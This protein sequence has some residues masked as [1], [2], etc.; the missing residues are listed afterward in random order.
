MLK[1]SAPSTK[2]RI[3]SPTLFKTRN[4]VSQKARIR[5]V[6]DCPFIQHCSVHVELSRL[7]HADSPSA[8]RQLSDEGPSNVYTRH[9]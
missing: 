4:L 7:A 8:L 9:F 3:H 1:M 2:Q 6:Q 5:S